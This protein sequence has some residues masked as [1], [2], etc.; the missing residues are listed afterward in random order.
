MNEEG[1]I[2][3]VSEIDKTTSTSMLQRIGSLT[4]LKKRKLESELTD[5]NEVLFLKREFEEER[6]KWKYE[7][8]ASKTEFDRYKLEC[9][10]QVKLK[11]KE[12]GYLKKSEAEL[13]SQ[14]NEMKR[15]VKFRSE[16]NQNLKKSE[17]ELKSQL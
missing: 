5:K 13:K 7:A 6:A 16:E 9:E 1:D 3:S 8:D 2:Q 17:A 12:I 14:L 11:S 10:F 4:G 15:D